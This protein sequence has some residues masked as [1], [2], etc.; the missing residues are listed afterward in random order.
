MRRYY[1]TALM[2]GCMLAQGGP[3]AAGKDLMPEETEALTAPLPPDDPRA[4][5]DPGEARSREACAASHGS[6]SGD[7][8]DA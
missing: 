7:R 4:Q 1:L 8:R 2:I 5:L 3:A 6:G